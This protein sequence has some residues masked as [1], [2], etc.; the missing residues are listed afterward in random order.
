MREESWSQFCP[1]SSAKEMLEGLV[2]M[3][4]SRD[5]GATGTAAAFFPALGFNLATVYELCRERAVDK[6]TDLVRIVAEKATA[7]G[8]G[9][10]ERAE[11][12][13]KL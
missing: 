12:E 10:W 9:G 2:G 6:K 4:G 11:W 8:C 13:F 5:N 7:P 3:S 1:F